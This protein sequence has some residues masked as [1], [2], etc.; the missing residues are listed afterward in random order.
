MANSSVMVDAIRSSD[1]KIDAE[2]LTTMAEALSDRAA[3]RIVHDMSA[4]PSMDTL[5][6]VATA[7]S[8]VT[9]AVESEVVAMTMAIARVC[10]ATP[11][12]AHRRLATTEAVEWIDVRFDQSVFAYFAT[13]TFASLLQSNSLH[14]VISKFYF[15]MVFYLQNYINLNLLQ[16]NY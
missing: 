16:S 3:P 6:A 13:Q 15:T 10:T 5:M 8:R 1:A 14:F 11:M 2:A 9:A 12:A 4:A 7:M